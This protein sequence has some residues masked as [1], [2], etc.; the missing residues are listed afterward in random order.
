MILQPIA[1]IAEICHQKG[2]QDFILSPG[3]RCAPLTIAL[4]R[5]PHITT[6]TIADERS[7]AFIAL[8]M[9]LQTGK[10]TGLVC[11]SGT[12]VL[13]YAPAVTEAYYQQIPLLILT[14][15]RPAEWVDQADGQTIRQ[16]GIY[17]NHIKASYQ[18]PSDYSHPDAVWAIER[19]ISEA[20]NIANTE[21]KGP[22]HI[23]IPLREPFYPE[24]GEEILYSSDVKVI[25]QL[26]TTT[27]LDE[28]SW[29]ELTAEFSKYKTCLLVA[30]Q[31]NA[32]EANIKK[33][34]EA[35]S[36]K[37]NTPVVADITANLH[38][39]THLISHQDFIL[40]KREEKVMEALK[41]DLL[42][43][44]GASVLSKNLKLFLR[45]HTPKAHWHIELNTKPADAFQSM[46]LS[47]PLKADLF[48]K[49]LAQRTKTYF[50]RRLSGRMEIYRQ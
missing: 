2:I 42:I 43:T 7:A 13:N 32:D 30:G 46:T 23:N 14:A 28:Q 40:A 36:N 10:I 6:R 3:S 35:F 18:L 26:T 29:Q 24:P 11:T 25:R 8:G 27:N 17:S 39:V 15:D 9:T 44:V 31:I 45:N 47:V 1:D 21:P 34:V 19:T 50:N 37:T 20:I 12:A 4:V 5:H 48:F 16:N 33:A 49:E 38:G 22:V 41:P